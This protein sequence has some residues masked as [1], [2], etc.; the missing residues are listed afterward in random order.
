MK[1][2]EHSPRNPCKYCGRIIDNRG[3]AAHIHFKHR[4]SVWA[5]F[6]NNPMVQYFLYG[7]IRGF[8]QLALPE[9]ASC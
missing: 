9:K 4:Q 2:I 3:L 6:A 7:E 5:E 1:T 8:V